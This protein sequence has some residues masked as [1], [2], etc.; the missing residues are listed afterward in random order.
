MPLVNVGDVVKANLFGIGV[1]HDILQ[2]IPGI[3]DA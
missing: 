2:W 3:G 1:K